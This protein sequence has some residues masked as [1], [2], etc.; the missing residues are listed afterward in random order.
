MMNRAFMIWI[1][2]SYDIYKYIFQE[3][4]RGYKNGGI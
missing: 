1:K 2:K 4:K 3:I